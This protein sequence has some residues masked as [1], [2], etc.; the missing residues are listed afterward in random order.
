LLGLVLPSLA[1]AQAT[2]ESPLVRDILALRESVRA[3]VAG[4]DRATLERLYADNF[5]HLRETG[6]ADVKGDRITLLLSGEATIETAPEDELDVQVYGPATAAATGVSPVPNAA[7]GK[8]ARF[9]W[10]VIYAKDEGGW[11]VALSQ[12]N[13][14]PDAR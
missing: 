3:A 14:V 11:K 4:K 10:L 12:A 9:R 8:P 1:W 6:R 2:G 7:T 5:T 13:R